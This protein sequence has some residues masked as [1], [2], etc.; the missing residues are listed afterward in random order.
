MDCP[1]VLGTGID[2]K[3]WGRRRGGIRK[4]G[5]DAEVRRGQESLIMKMKMMRNT[6]MEEKAEVEVEVDEGREPRKTLGRCTAVVS[7]SLLR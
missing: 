1:A 7:C 5:E 6:A 2:K 3:Y 4:R